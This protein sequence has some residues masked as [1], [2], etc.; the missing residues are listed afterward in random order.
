MISQGLI[1]FRQPVLK[2]FLHDLTDLL[3]D[4]L[5]LLLE[6]TVVDHLLGEGM[7]EDVLQVGLERPCPDEVQS[8]EAH[9]A[10]VDLSP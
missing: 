3:M 4:V 2:E 10:L 7:F 5:A 8:F 1:E 6:E 9:Q